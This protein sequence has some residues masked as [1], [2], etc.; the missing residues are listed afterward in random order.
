MWIKSQIFDVKICQIFQKNLQN[1]AVVYNFE[2][3]KM[4]AFDLTATGFLA[5]FWGKYNNRYE[6]LSIVI[7]S[8]IR[9][10][11]SI[12]FTSS[13]SAAELLLYKQIYQTPLLGRLTDHTFHGHKFGQIV[14]DHI[15]WPHKSNTTTIF[16]A[17]VPYYRKVFLGSR[18]D[19]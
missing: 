8:A 19:M 16:L 5:N 13:N 17:F 7:S 6:P 12:F 11:L 18:F 14:Y 3:A 10:I 15:K 1:I 4:L 9:W 2:G